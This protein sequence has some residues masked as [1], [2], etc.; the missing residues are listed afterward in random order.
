MLLPIPK[1]STPSLA[2]PRIRAHERGG[3]VWRRSKHPASRALSKLLSRPTAQH[4]RAPGTS[5]WTRG[6]S[7][8]KTGEGKTHLLTG[9]R[10]AALF[11]KT[12]ARS[13]IIGGVLSLVVGT[14]QTVTL[15]LVNDGSGP[16]DGSF[17]GMPVPL[18]TV[19]GVGS[20]ASF[21][22]PAFSFA[23]GAFPGTG[24]TAASTLDPWA[25]AT[26]VVS[27]TPTTTGAFSTTLQI[28]YFDGSQNQV[29]SFQL[30]G[31]AL[32]A[33]ALSILSTPYFEKNRGSASDAAFTVTNSGQWPASNIAAN[34]TAP[35]TRCVRHSLH[36]RARRRATQRWPL[37]S[38]PETARSY[39]LRASA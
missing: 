15:N 10:C 8:R 16:D 2:V 17:T 33:A 1:Y 20:G 13:L 4:W 24:G 18:T 9:K 12:P 34:T 11:Q 22:S 32:S 37:N 27:F 39:S 21:G 23:G 25:G 26:V 30:T 29:A 19:T 3:A 5:V 35:F 6:S 36:E 28:P 7:Y 38:T 31:T 14:T